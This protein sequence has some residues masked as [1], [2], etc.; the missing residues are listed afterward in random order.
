MGGPLSGSG[1]GSDGPGDVR[2]SRL[3]KPGSGGKSSDS[4]LP[5]RS[6][7]LVDRVGGLY[8]LRR[9]TIA[10]ERARR[11]KHQHVFTWK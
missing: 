4:Q 3:Q 7:P 8:L 2:Y 9:H 11:L 10:P 6:M 5:P 1:L